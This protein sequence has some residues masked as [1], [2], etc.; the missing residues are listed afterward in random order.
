MLL[1]KILERIRPLDR[2]F[3][4]EAQKRLDS[5]TKPQ[6]SLGKLEELAR[7]VAGIQGKVPPRLGRKLLFVFAADHGITEEGVSAYPKEVTAQ[8]TY[9]FLRGGAAINV[10]ARHYGVEVEVIDVGVDYEFSEPRGLRNCKI[11]RGTSNFSRGAAMSRPEAMQSIE[12]GIRLV[13]EIASENLFLLGAGEMGIGN[14][15]S[16][17][18]ILCA[19]TGAA[20]RDVVGRGTGI[21]D[22]TW[23]RKVVAIERGLELNRP[24]AKDPLD[25]LTK[26]GGL[27]IGAMTGVILGA[28][29]VQIPMVLDGFISGAAALLAQRLCPP[30]QDFLFASHLSPEAG[31]KFMLEALKLAPVLDLAMRLGEGTGACV[32]MGLTEAAARL[33]GEMATFESAG[34]EK[35]LS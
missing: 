8:M 16:A 27:E 13:E 1:E 23:R 5:L 24:D 34:V 6:G 21:D 11:R 15:S 4:V 26:V 33:L 25:V 12:T 10:L 35:K 22:P 32:L 7:R 28:A 17:A 3:E 20:P 2:S 30:V 19:L 18:A 31:H 14:T 29:A 9:N